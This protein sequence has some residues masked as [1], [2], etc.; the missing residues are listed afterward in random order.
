MKK[1]IF[2]LL[3]VLLVLTG[4]VGWGLFGPTVND[5]QTSYLYLTSPLNKE[6]LLEKL[7]NEKIISTPRWASLLMK[8]GEIKKVKAGRYKIKKGMSVS[9]LVRNLKNGKHTPVKLVINKIRTTEELAG[10]IGNKLDFKIDSTELINYLRNID[11]LKAFSVDTNQVLSIVMPYTYELNWAESPSQL[12]Q[13]FYNS[14][15]QFWTAENIK[16]AKKKGLTPLKVSTLASIVEEE[17][18]RKVDR[19]NIASTYFQPI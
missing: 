3:M 4:W 18:N 15:N 6:A 17:T 19:Y 7:I 14:W 2:S 12:L 8:M 13:Q 1:I 10:L 5:Q 16:K 11:S 9:Q